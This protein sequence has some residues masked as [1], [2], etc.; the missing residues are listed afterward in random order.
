MTN[1]ELQYRANT[2]REKIATYKYPADDT[3]TERDKDEMEYCDLVREMIKRKL[4]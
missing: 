4:I 3:P 2:L 1:A